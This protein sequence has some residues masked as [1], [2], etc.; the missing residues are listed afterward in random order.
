MK[1]DDPMFYVCL[2]LIGLFAL[3]VLMFGW[4]MCRIS[5]VSDQIIEEMDERI[6]ERERHQD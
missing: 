2:L 3:G 5:A 4:S 1:G 6:D